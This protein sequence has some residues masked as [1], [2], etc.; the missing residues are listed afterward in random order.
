M[1]QFIF[2]SGN[3]SLLATQ[4]QFVI[5]VDSFGNFLGTSIP[6]LSGTPAQIK[7]QVMFIVPL[8]S[9]GNTLS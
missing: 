3:P 4:V 8:D 1:T 6:C 2:A 9:N 5:P 7:S